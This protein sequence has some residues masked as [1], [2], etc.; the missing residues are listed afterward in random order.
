MTIKFDTNG[1]ALENGEVTVYITDSNNIFT[2][3]TIEQ[4]FQ[5]CG[6]SAG[7]YLDEPPHPQDGYVI[8]RENDEWVQK[9]N[10]RGKFAYKKATGEKVEIKEIGEIS[11]D[12]TL[13]KPLNEPCKW[14]GEA[15]VIDEVKKSELK[16]QQQEQVWNQIKDTRYKHTHSGVYVASVNKWF[17]T[18]DPSRIQYISL[19]QLPEIPEGLKW[20]TMNNS[21]ITMTKALIAELVTS[22]MLKEQADF[23]NTERHRVAMLQSDNP[24]EYDFSDGWSEIYGE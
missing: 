21:F 8:V 11:D 1:I 23:A 2:H 20:K 12:L 9:A 6:L 3:S 14:N 19:Q 5:G 16:K 17:H 15:W 13:L 7:A 4:V 24:L 18:D 10:H 22:I